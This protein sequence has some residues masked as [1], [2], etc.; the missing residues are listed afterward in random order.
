[1]PASC[2]CVCPSCALSGL[3]KTRFRRERKKKRVENDEPINVQIKIVIFRQISSFAFMVADDKIPID[4][5]LRT[6]LMLLFLFSPV[7]RILFCDGI[8]MRTDTKLCALRTIANGHNKK[9]TTEEEA[10]NCYDLRAEY[11]RI[12]RRFNSSTIFFCGYKFY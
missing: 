7:I 8:E 3:P 12:C 10:A 9:K 2:F 4:F 5:S 1:M 6:H 11:I